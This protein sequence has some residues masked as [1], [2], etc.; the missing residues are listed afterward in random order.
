MWPAEAVV[1]G[2]LIVPLPLLLFL[3]L[4]G[5]EKGGYKERNRGM[6][7]KRTTKG[8]LPELLSPHLHSEE[9][10]PP[11]ILAYS[12]MSHTALQSEVA[13]L[14]N[15]VI[16]VCGIA[17]GSELSEGTSPQWTPL[18]ESF[19]AEQK[20]TNGVAWLHFAPRA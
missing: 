14:A 8:S 7:E 10:V 12:A 6:A 9:S 18:L 13:P 1:S 16:G 19:P 15:Y 4:R 3:L 11:T 2:Q 17:R 20:R 5:L